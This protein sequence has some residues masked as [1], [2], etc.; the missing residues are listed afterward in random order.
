[1]GGR[2]RALADGGRGAARA[3]VH[4]AASLAKQ[5]LSSQEARP[6]WLSSSRAHGKTNTRPIPLP[7]GSAGLFRQW[8][9]SG[10]PL[11]GDDSST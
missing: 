10:P 9:A 11:Q 5:D 8:L 1:M 3:H 7:L 6:P 4:S 2:P